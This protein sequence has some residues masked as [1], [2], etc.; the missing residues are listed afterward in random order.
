MTTIGIDI[1]TTSISGVILTRRPG[2]GPE[3]GTENAARISE[4]IPNGTDIAS[5]HPWESLQDIDELTARAK[6]LLD[7]LIARCGEIPSAVG[8]TGQMHGIVYVDKKGKAVSPLYTWQDR[9]GS[10]IAAAAERITDRI[11]A[12]GYGI[13]THLYNLQHGLVPESAV[14]ICT[15]ADYFG[16]ALTGRTSPLVHVS[17]AASLGFWDTEGGCF[18]EEAIT[19][20]AESTLNR[21]ADVRDVLRFLPEVTADTVSLGACRGIPVSIAIGDNQASFLGTVGMREETLLVN[22]GT[23]GQVSMIRSGRMP[24]GKGSPSVE[25]RPYIG[26]RFLL[27]GASL[28][29]GSAYAYLERFFRE[30]VREAA[31]IDAEQYEP[32]AK[33]ARAAMDSPATGAGGSGPTG[34][35]DVATTF[36]GTR[37]DESVRG[38]I[39]GL[40]GDNLKP[41]LLILGFLRGMIGELAELYRSMTAL[42]SPEAKR[43]VASGNGMRRNAVLC[44][45]AAAAFAL[46]LEL[47]EAEEEAAVGAAEFAAMPGIQ[48]LQKCDTF[49]PPLPIQ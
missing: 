47:A 26:G 48:M 7:S 33:L 34:I 2:A 41:G 4:S 5:P 3:S 45:I 20:V 25:I 15:A 43:I 19:A 18:D 38:S 27:V 24:A 49:V 44:D 23:G 22:M 12:A 21:T 17:N 29:G 14:T 37:A 30:Y 35:P 36:S 28:C 9:R 13:I 42:G 31:G 6:S 39:R 32:M 8:L 46:P 40:T 1:G 16:M 11:A 10:G